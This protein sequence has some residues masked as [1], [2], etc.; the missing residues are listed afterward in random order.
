MLAES[1]EVIYGNAIKHYMNRSVLARTPGSAGMYCAVGACLYFWRNLQS[2]GFGHLGRLWK[3]HAALVPAQIH[4]RL[5][6][7]F[8]PCPH[9]LNRLAPQATSDNVNTTQ[10]LAS[11]AAVLPS[12]PSASR[13]G[14]MLR[15]GAGEGRAAFIPPPRFSS[16]GQKGPPPN[17]AAILRK[18]GGADKNT[19]DKACTN[20]HEN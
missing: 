18:T 15:R 9:L 1:T 17:P 11:P 19:E 4:L 6:S 16:R 2:K 12:P 7:I 3:Q 5:G 10:Q 8:G 20:V 13:G 14:R